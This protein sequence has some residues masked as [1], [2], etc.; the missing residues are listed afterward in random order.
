VFVLRLATVGGLTLAVAT[1]SF[2][3]VERPLMTWSHRRGLPLT[4][5]KS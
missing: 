5:D 3:L 4:P 2:Y 1:A